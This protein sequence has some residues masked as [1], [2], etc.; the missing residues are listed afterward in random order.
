[1]KV[2][3]GCKQELP[4]KEFHYLGRGLRHSKCN[5]CR[6]SYAKEYQKKRNKL[7]HQKLW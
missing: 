2:C 5:P 3:T 6:Q 7:I 1:M 4:K